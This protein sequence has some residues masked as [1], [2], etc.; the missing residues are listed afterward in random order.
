[1]LLAGEEGEGGAL[2]TD[3]KSA[4]KEG[5]VGREEKERKMGRVDYLHV[6]P[7]LMTACPHITIASPCARDGTVRERERRVW[8]R[9]GQGEAR[10]GRSARCEG[11]RL[12]IE[13]ARLGAV[14]SAM[15][16]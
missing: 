8:E 7:S 2:L 14:D 16:P 13:G 6:P 9:E 4:K 12:G 15:K 10:E 1:M 5:R 3:S 11:V